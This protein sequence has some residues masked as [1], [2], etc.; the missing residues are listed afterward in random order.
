MCYFYQSITCFSYEAS[1][2]HVSAMYSRHYEAFS[3]ANTKKMRWEGH[4][5]NMRGRKWDGEAWTGLSGSGQ[6]QVAGTCE[7][8]NEHSGSRKFGEFLN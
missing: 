2:V 7:C 5:A 4:V 3:P 8:R 1:F 6:G